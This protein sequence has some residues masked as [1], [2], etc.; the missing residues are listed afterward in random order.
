MRTCQDFCAHAADSRHGCLTCNVDETA[1]TR[2]VVE[3]TN[4][5]RTATDN[6][7]TL[8]TRNSRINSDSSKTRRAQ[9]IVTGPEG[10]KIG[11][12]PALP[13]VRSR[14]RG[15][16]ERGRG[17]AVAMIKTT[18]IRIL[19]HRPNTTIKRSI[20]K[21]GASQFA[22]LSTAAKAA[23]VRNARWSMYASFA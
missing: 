18:R 7:G 20:G 8:A 19:S 11:L 10:R 3:R 12:L 23:G 16:K 13:P 2:Q 6:A 1:P 9:K 17:G 22:S 4:E 5:G 15:T 14:R 21:L